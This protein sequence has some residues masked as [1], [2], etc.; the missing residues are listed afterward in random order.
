MLDAHESTVTFL[1][2]AVAAPAEL[3]T[4]RAA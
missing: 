1:D 3:R 4:D 2:G